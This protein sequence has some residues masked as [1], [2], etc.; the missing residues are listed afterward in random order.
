MRRGGSVALGESRAH[1][2]ICQSVVSTVG[3][4]GFLLVM[5]WEKWQGNVRNLAVDDIV[6]MRSESRLDHE[7]FCLAKMGTL[8]PDE[9]GQDHMVS[10]QLCNRRCRG[11]QSPAEVMKMALQSIA[12]LLP[13]EEQ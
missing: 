11:N 5:P 6:L 10:F 1:S 8:H 3:D 7:P 2:T 12:V 13:V 9:A 4:Q